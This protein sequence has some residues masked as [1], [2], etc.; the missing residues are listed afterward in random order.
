MK[1]V[2]TQVRKMRNQIKKKFFIGKRE[3]IMAACE[4]LKV[5]AAEIIPGEEIKEL[6][7][8]TRNYNTTTRW[9]TV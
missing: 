3:N 2:K 4:N 9:Q 6:E 1:N 8:Y 7:E 5:M